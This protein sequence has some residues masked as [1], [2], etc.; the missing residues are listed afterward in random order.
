[1]KKSFFIIG[2]L[3]MIL[4]TD[5]FAQAP[6]ENAA[7]GKAQ[8]AV[9]RECGPEAGP[10]SHEVIATT[11]CPG[12]GNSYV[13]FFYQPTPCFPQPGP[14]IQVIQPIATATVDC[15]GDVTVV[16]GGGGPVLIE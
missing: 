2:V 15:N 5:A 14:C 9:R 3:M 1:M 12:G 13:I 8:G 7:V 10:L 6:N 4:C 16:C 11:P